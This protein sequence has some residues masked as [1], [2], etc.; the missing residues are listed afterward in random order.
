[1]THFFVSVL[2]IV[3]GFGAVGSVQAA[4]GTPE[5]PFVVYMILFRGCEEACQG[6]KAHFQR[7]QIPVRF[8]DRDCGQDRKKVAGFVAEAKRIKPD[9]VV[10]WGTG[11]TLDALGP[12]DNIDPQKHITQ[13]PAVFMIVSQPVEAKIVSSLQGSGRNITG[14]GYLIP[15][16]TQLRAAARYVKFSRLGF[17]YNPL[18]ANSQ[19]NL[20]E[21]E[22][23]QGVLKFQ[24]IARAVPLGA[25][26][27]PDKNLIADLVR[28]LS[29][30]K[31]DLIYQGPDT[32]LNV[33][34]DI[35][36]HTAVELKIPVFAA[37]ENPVVN[38]KALLG[39]VNRY[40]VVGNFTAY[41]AARILVD[42]VDPKNIPIEAPRKYSFI[43]NMPV[44]RALGLYPPM[45]VVQIA[46]VI[47]SK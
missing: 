21:L 47:D 18:E 24:L 45:R 7:N 44:A 34:R 5:D 13:I 35:L 27:K 3:S 15:E 12:Y 4:K 42:K 19:V 14:T 2:L 20:K 40:S 46:E 9:L 22:R 41:Q 25:D 38:S 30:Q 23:L 16:E 31:V 43:I 26:K 10:T 36:T 1:M 39:V 8:V 29:K 28:E 17:I 33:N 37:A 32:F 6:F 11:V